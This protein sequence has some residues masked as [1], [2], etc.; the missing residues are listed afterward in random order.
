LACWLLPA[1]V[2]LA[3]VL[4]EN[5]PVG[6]VPEAIRPAFAA[7]PGIC[8]F[9]SRR[10]LLLFF[11]APVSLVMLLNAVFFTSSALMIH[12]SSVTRTDFRLYLR[13][14]VLMGVTWS[15]GLL[16]GFL[17]TPALWVI[18]VVLNSLQGLFIFLAFTCT[19]SV[20]KEVKDK[21]CC[22]CLRRRKRGVI[23]SDSMKVSNGAKVTSSAD[24]LPW[25]AIS[26][27]AISTKSSLH[28][29][30]SGRSTDETLY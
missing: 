5:A 19:R 28:S 4:V 10:S 7:R 27:S 26:S 22:C 2:V 17:D 20:L 12:T 13:L 23:N 30:D 9:T 6:S 1:L 18:F 25:S 15:V 29:I 8:W 14:A 11:A 24:L 3:A 21:C 16:A